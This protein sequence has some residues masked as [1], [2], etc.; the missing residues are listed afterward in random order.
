MVATMLGVLD[1]GDEVV[2][3]EPYYDDYHPDVMADP[4]VACGWR[5]ATR[6]G[7]CG[8]CYAYLRRTGR[9]RP[10]ELLIREGRRVLYRRQF[11]DAWSATIRSALRR[12]VCRT[13][14]LRSDLNQSNGRKE[15][16]WQRCVSG[17]RT[18]IPMTG[19]SMNDATLNP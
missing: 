12:L 11:A 13:Q 17:I 10:D 14:S 7:R 1:L 15:Q 6:N 16:P 9:D 18:A 3:F 8:S 4:C 5:D 2:I 19:P